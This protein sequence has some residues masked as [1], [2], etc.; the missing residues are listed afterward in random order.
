M[1]TLTRMLIVLL[2]GSFATSANADERTRYYYTTNNAFRVNPLGLISSNTL[3]ARYRLFEP[4]DLL[5][6]ETYAGLAIVPALSGGFG[7][8]GVLAEVQPLALLRLWAR[9]DAVG[10]FGTFN[11]F[12]SFQSPNADFSDTK[13]SEL[14]ALEAPAKNYAAAGFQ[15]T[16][17]IDLKAK[18]GPFAFRSL[19]RFIHSNFNMR[20]GDTVFFD[21]LYDQLLPNNGWGLSNDFDLLY[22]TDFGLIAGLRTNL[23]M[24]FYGAEHFAEGEI[25][26]AAGDPW[27]QNGPIVRSGPLLAYTFFD[28]PGARFNKPTLI[29]NTQ[30]HVLH[31]FRTG[32]DVNRFVPYAFVAFI[33]TGDLL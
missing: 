12:Q 23:G 33:M 14:G 24:Q 16:L 17:G 20:E 3:G 7:K 11:L 29:L 13:L 31:R 4:D 8:V 6:S 9:F 10:Y 27:E 30:F 28:E 5:F 22:L 1:N 15:T 26:F 25:A 18:Y 2:I 19:T 32:Q 21:Q